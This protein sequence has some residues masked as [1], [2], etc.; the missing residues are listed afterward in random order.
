MRLSKYVALQVN[1]LEEFFEVG[2]FE[3][4]SC[5]FVEVD[6]VGLVVEGRKFLLDSSTELIVGGV[7]LEVDID[8]LGYRVHADR[9]NFTHQ[10]SGLLMHLR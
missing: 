7:A 5:H 4:D 10:Y 1:S 9:S 2:P 8:S 6:D 3:H